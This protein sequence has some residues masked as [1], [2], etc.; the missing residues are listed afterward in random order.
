VDDFE[1]WTAY[2]Y[3]T[4]KLP[5]RIRLTGG[6]AYE[7]MRFPENFRSPP[8][9]SGGETR[10]RLDPKAA[11]VW[12]ALPEAT[13][14]GAYMRSLGGVS[15]DESFR[16][17]PTQLAGFNQAFRTLIPES[18]VGSVSA[19]ELEVWGAALDLKFKTRT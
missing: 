11:V 13:V 7:H 16:L 12:E 15:L 14:R 6:F 4:L 5:G 18:L 9:Q 2:G 19:P 10:E 3:E 1:R 17:E 8:I